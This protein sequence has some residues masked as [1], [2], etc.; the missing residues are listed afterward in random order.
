ML[1]VTCPPRVRQ[2]HNQQ[3][4]TKSAKGPDPLDLHCCTLY[5]AAH[6]P[7]MDHRPITRYPPTPGTVTGVGWFGSG[8]GCDKS[9]HQGN[10][11][12]WNVVSVKQG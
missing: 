7:C 3:K 2:N 8:F 1:Q 12:I 6:Q 9:R 5:S 4:P 11:A 10:Y